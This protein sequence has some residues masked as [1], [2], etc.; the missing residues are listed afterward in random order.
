MVKVTTMYLHFGT[1]VPGEDQ[2]CVHNATATLLYIITPD[3]VYTGAAATMM[4][5]RTADS[6]S[7]ACMLN[8]SLE[9]W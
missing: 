1:C 5:N 3:H 2:Q 7:S 4:P 8:W 9:Q 6:P